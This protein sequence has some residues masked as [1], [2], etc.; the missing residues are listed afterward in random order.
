MK[1][2]LKKAFAV[3]WLIAVVTLNSAHGAGLS[4]TGGTTDLSLTGSVGTISGATA[5]GQLSV[6]VSA[7]VLPTLS[8][9]ISSNTLA[10]GDLLVG[11]YTRTNLTYTWVTNA[12]NGMAV[13]VRS[14]TLLDDGN[15]NKIWAGE[16]ANTAYK[17][18]KNVTVDDGIGA[19]FVAGSDLAL[20]DRANNG[21]IGGVMNI[22]AKID[23]ATIA[24]NYT[25][26]LVFSVTW[27]F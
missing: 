15:G 14:T 7:T 18:G 16:Q 27:N 24:G 5:T 17:F 20:D 26:T 21:A 13:T 12:L 19:D 6:G 8:F 22:G 2:L 1:T 11:D 3:A 10:L 9:E 25:D 23:A 4:L